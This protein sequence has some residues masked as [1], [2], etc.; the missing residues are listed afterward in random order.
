MEVITAASGNEGIAH[1]ESDDYGL[2]LCDAYMPDRDGLAVFEEV[3]RRWSALPFVFMT[4]Y[5]VP[6]ERDKILSEAAGIL[7][8][9]AKTE[10]FS[11]M[12]ESFWPKDKSS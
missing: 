2:V 3:Y 9:P 10:Q 12:V 6:A 7:E 4:G 5:S 1:L 11:A 8:K